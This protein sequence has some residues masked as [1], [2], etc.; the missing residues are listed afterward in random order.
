MHFGTSKPALFKHPVSTLEKTGALGSAPGPRPSHSKPG[1]SANLLRSATFQQPSHNKPHCS[2]SGD[3]Q[4]PVA[5]VLRIK[6]SYLEEV[7]Y[8]NS[9][10]LLLELLH[11]WLFTGVREWRGD[12]TRETIQ[13]KY[14]NFH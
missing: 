14:L 4:L 2:A 13:G 8:F 3:N 9:I 5:A 12:N 6:G 10:C 11:I 7:L 1:R